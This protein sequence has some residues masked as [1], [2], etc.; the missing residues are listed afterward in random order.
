[1]TAGAGSVVHEHGR[2]TRL[3]PGNEVRKGRDLLEQVALAGATRTELDRVVIRLDE[4]D[5]PQEHQILGPLAEGRWLEAD[6]PEQDPLPLLRG[7]VR[8]V[9]G[10]L[11]GNIPARNLDR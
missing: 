11:L 6:T 10:D 3:S 8:A 1:Q 5:H 4:R 9:V 2:D 7:E